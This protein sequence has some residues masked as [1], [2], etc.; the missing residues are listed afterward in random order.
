MFPSNDGPP[1]KENNTP[2]KIAKAL[3]DTIAIIDRF[4]E[5]FNFIPID[6]DYVHVVIGVLKT[7]SDVSNSF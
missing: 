2:D 6:N 5:V 1:E 3:G 4:K 7:I